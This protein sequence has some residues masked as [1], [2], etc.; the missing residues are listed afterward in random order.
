MK[1]TYNNSTRSFSHVGRDG[2]EKA[3]L[4]ANLFVRQPTMNQYR[5][6]AV[7]P[8]EGGEVEIPLT[9][10]SQ[11]EG[12]NT[13][14]VEVTQWITPWGE[15]IHTDQKSTSA[16]RD[17]RAIAGFPALAQ[18][19]QDLR[20]QVRH[21]DAFLR[22]T[23]E[24]IRLGARAKFESTAGFKVLTEQLETGTI[25]LAACKGAN[26]ELIEDVKK[27][28]HSIAKGYAQYERAYAFDPRVGDNPEY[29][30]RGYIDYDYQ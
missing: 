8:L 23:Q 7:D 21:R 27:T 14:Q 12:E 20:N 25:N 4:P 24:L 29:W 5:C 26:Q 17:A 3:I 11:I 18:K 13:A 10:T 15:V 2:E 30:D 28:R 16:A 1:R 6:F 19:A 9:K 22:A